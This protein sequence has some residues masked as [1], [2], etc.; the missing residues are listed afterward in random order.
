MCH[1]MSVFFL[2][3]DRGCVVLSVDNFVRE[4][5]LHWDSLSAGG[6]VD[7]PTQRE[8]LL[9]LE[10]N[11]HGNLVGGA[12]NTATLHLEARAR[13]FQR[14]E[15]EINRVA[16]LE[17]LG[18]FFKSAVN[19]ALSKILLAA[20]HDDIDEVRDQRAVVSNVRNDLALLSSVTT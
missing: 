8:R 16:L 17:L 1:L 2:L 10:R 13:I 11:F 18:N 5:I 19:N 9:T 14:T 20:L 12:T 7:D 6:C 15:H 4:G 3:N